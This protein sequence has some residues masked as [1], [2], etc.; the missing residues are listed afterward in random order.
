MIRDELGKL[1]HEAIK[2]AQESGA[3]PQFDIPVIP[4]ERPKQEQHGDYATP[5][6]LQLA[7]LARMVPIRIAEIL[8]SHLPQSDFVGK[9]EVA[10]PGYINFALS[11]A[12]LARQVDEILTTGESWGDLD[13]GHGRKVQVEYVSANPTGPLHVGSGRNAVVGDAVAN[14]LAAAGWQVQREY[15]INDAGT[16]MGLF[17]ETLYVRYAQA[18]GRDE[19][20]PEGGY[21]GAYMEEMGQ[22]IARE[23]GPKFLEMDPAQ[24]VAALTDIGLAHLVETI[25]ADLSFMG[26]NFDR[27]FSERTLYQDGTFEH[28]LALLRQSNYVAERDGAVWFTTTDLGGDKDEVIV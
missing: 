27:W 24:A 7:G 10:R 8:V 22:R 3:L 2:R 28:V 21:Q 6:C 14:V 4:V 9:A 26:V 18:L 15:Y 16:Q 17:G 13:L 5:V 19:H 23:H 12:W 1:V 25:R 20:L 11:E